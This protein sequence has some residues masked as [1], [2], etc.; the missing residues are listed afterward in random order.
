MRQLK[1]Y[2]SPYNMLI[3]T[4]FKNLSVP[5]IPVVDRKKKT[6]FSK[7]GACSNTAGFEVILYSRSRLLNILYFAADHVLFRKQNVS[8]KKNK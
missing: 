3:G 7:N 2:Q 8:R 4:G 5:S 1:Y 6:S